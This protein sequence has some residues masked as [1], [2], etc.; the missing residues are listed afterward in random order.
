MPN[1][2]SEFEFLRSKWEFIKIDKVIRE[3]MGVL[4]LK[5]LEPLLNEIKL[6]LVRVDSVKTTLSETLLDEFTS[7][8]K[9]LIDYLTGVA[10][11]T[12]QQFV[13][14]REQIKSTV[15]RHNE[16]ILNIWPQIVAIII[17]NNSNVEFEEMFEELRILKEQN[18]DSNIEVEKRLEELRLLKEKTDEDAA[19]IE[20]LKNSLNDDITT[21][22]ERYKNEI[23]GKAEILRQ[24]DTFFKDAQEFKRISR[25]WFI[26]IIFTSA[27]LITIL[28]FVFKQFCFELVCFDETCTF[29]YDLICKGCNRSVLNLEIFKAIAFRV[30][31]ISFLSYLINICVRNYNANMHNYTVNKHKANSL[32][33]ALILLDKAKTDDGN[34]QIMTQAAN[35]IFSHQPTGFNKKDPEN[36]ASITEKVI[37][38]MR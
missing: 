23:F 37:E 34:D 31:L 20:R 14:T 15:H 21:F 27:L 36:I 25:N 8:V 2:N 30:V 12:D 7:I 9:E 3:E 13:T 32:S 17:D 5:D 18:N 6:K 33:A 22:N 4:S 35:A 11:L 26:G 24:E 16:E 29:N 38:K 1:L 28:F 10:K 19:T